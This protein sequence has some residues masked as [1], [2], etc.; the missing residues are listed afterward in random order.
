MR[1]PLRFTL[2]LMPIEVDIMAT[3]ITDLELAWFAGFF[4]GEGCV[5]IT[6]HGSSA[7][8]TLRMMLVN[9]DAA[10][11]KRLAVRYG[12]RLQYKQHFGR[13]SHWK[14][15]YQIV[16]TQWSAFALL[17]RLLP[18]LRLKR[19][20]AKL[21]IRFCQFQAQ[22]K[23][24]RCTTI[25]KRGDGCG[26]SYPYQRRTAKTLAKEAAFKDAMHRLNRK[27]QAHADQDADHK[28]R[29]GRR[30]T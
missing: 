8:T 27:G 21:A 28:S 23:T 20:Q 25:K 16:W 13:V 6:T 17:C 12:G 2:R 7:Q 1:L 18:H 24:V 3:K 14:P 22:P 29:K 26:R 4:D 19:R 10:L 15:S 30:S 11:M 5:N 9:T